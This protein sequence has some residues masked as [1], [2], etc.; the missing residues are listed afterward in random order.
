VEAAKRSVPEVTDEF[1]AKVKAGLTAES[2]MTELKKA[3]DEVD[4]K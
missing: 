4:S 2:L 1:S 3:I